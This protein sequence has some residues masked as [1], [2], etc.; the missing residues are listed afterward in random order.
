MT[1]WYPSKCRRAID[2]KQIGR[3]PCP[4]TGRMLCQSADEI[5]LR[6]AR[7]WSVFLSSCWALWSVVTVEELG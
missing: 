3:R 2:V 5:R 1:L 4:K 6:A 7:I